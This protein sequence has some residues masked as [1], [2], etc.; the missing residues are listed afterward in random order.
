MSQPLYLAITLDVE[1]E[2]LF[3]GSYPRSV[4]GVANVA[5][6]KRLEFIARDFGFPLTLLVTYP[7]AQ[8]SAAREVLAALQQ[9]RG[10]E[11]GVHL[12]PWNTPPFTELL[13]P[14]PIPTSRL[15]LTL[16]KAK[17]RSLVDC[18]TEAFQEPPRSF[19]MGRF[20]WSPGLLK[21]LPGSG[22]RVDS[23]MVPLTFKGEGRENFLT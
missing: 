18:L 15:P 9:E 20:D 14:E 7:V 11:I 3:S 23:S 13:D 5:E 21:L 2:G 19:R 12:H 10:A 4:S 17:L 6:L 16:M 1:E 8:D 22:L